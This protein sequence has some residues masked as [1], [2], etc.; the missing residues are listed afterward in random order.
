MRLFG[1]LLQHIPDPVV[2]INAISGEWRT[3]I[4]ET[5]NLWNTRRSY[6]VHPRDP[7]NSLLEYEY[8]YWQI[9]RRFILKES[10]RQLV[11]YVPRAPLERDV[12]S[13]FLIF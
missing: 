4:N 7:P 6:I 2:P 1:Y 12:V 9:T 13:I 5:L 10:S 11:A 3:L 8:W